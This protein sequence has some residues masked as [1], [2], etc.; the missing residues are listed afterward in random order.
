M[1]AGRKFIGLDVH[2]DTIAIAVADEGNEKEVRFFGTIANR[3]EALHAALKRIGQD[4]S[5]LR[6][7]YESGPCGF[8][9]YRYLIRIGVECMVI[10]P[11]SMPRRPADRI[12]TDRRDAQTLA[13][14]LRAG[15]L[16]AVW[17]PD[18]AHEAIRDVVRARRQAKNDLSA[19]KTALKSFLLRHDRRFTGKAIWGKAHWRWLSDQT[20]DF[21]HQQFVYE[22][23]KRRIHELEDRCDRLNEVL[24]QAVSGWALAPL[25]HALQALRGVK[26]TAAVTL[27]AEIGDLHRFDSPK[28]LMAWLGL[29]PAE[30]SSGKRIKRGEIT[31]TGNAAARTMLIE[32]AWHYRFPAREGLALRRRN[33][34]IPDH[35]RAIAWKAQVRLCAKFRRLAAA[36]KQTVKV[37]TAVARELAGFI[38]DIARHTP[39]VAVPVRG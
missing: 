30:H 19:A 32:S 16:I 17:V 38:W 36:G 9:I 27:V 6:V 2:Q 14:L 25:V 18:E 1:S 8:V 33:V 5:E 23:Y 3:P 35:I 24:A 7:C 39:V 28:Q 20:F 29:V 11:S 13:R 22:E 10:S 21:P 26:L 31:R 34:E 37:V 4:V 12:K 15:E